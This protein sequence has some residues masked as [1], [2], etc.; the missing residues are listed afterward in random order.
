MYV[1][2]GCSKFH[3]TFEICFHLCGKMLPIKKKLCDSSQLRV[4]KNGVLNN[5]KKKKIPFVV[6]QQFVNNENSTATVYNVRTKYGRKSVL[7]LSSQTRLFKKFAGTGSVRD[8]KK[9]WSSFNKPFTI[10]SKN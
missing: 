5:K 4:I 3:A 8:H 1:F 2:K 9:G 10:F 7:T 6:K